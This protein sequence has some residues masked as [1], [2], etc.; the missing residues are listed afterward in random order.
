MKFVTEELKHNV[1]ETMPKANEEQAAVI[2][3][4]PSAYGKMLSLVM[5]FGTEIGWY[6]NVERS[7]D[8]PSRFV[9]RNILVY[10]Q[11]VDGAYI[12]VDEENLV[13][14]MIEQDKAG[15]TAPRN[16]QCHSHVN[17]AV[18]PSGTDLEHQ[19]TILEMLP[20]DEF[21]IFMIWNKRLDWNAW[22]YDKANNVVFDKRN[23]TVEIDDSGTVLEDYVESAKG[24][25][26]DRR[27]SY[28][29]HPVTCAKTVEWDDEPDIEQSGN[30]IGVLRQ[31]EIEDFFRDAGYE[32]SDGEP[33][34]WFYD[35]WTE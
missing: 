34:D 32:P 25:L 33:E 10:P 23:I 17:M 26:T 29:R 22:I 6:G 13:E 9:V 19:G 18:Q 27:W 3:F 16:M 5:S 11:T 20:K 8:N 31:T 24:M 14:W 2:Q 15:N 30:S 7:I 35:D 1:L 21:Y 28:M 12:D 4:A